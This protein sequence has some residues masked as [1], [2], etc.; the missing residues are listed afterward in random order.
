MIDTDAGLD[1]AQAILMA[2][3]DQDVEIVGITCCMGNTSVSQVSRNVLRLLKLC[4]RL[5]VSMYVCMYVCMFVC[6]Y[7]CL[8]VCMYI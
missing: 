8:Y 4:D 1:D 3:A 6:M 5:D 7:V 2:L